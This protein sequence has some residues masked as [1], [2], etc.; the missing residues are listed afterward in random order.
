MKKIIM[1]YG[2]ECPH[3]HVMMPI[4]DKI[5]K[6]SK[7]KIKFEKLEVWHN[8]DNLD[9]IRKFK[10]FLKG[11]CGGEILF[12]TFFD[13]KNKRGLCGERSYAQLIAWINEA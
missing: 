2:E 3:C 5:E 13:L 1:F 8:P 7:G 12:P 10:I 6:E 11:Q 9:Y 4:V